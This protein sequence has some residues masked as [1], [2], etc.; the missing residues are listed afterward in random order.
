[1]V[2]HPTALK[3]EQPL[4]RFG[5]VADDVADTMHNGSIIIHGNARDVIG[6]AIQGGHIFVRGA[7]GNRAA[8]QMREYQ[9]NRPCLIIGETAEDYLA[10]YMAGGV[11]V[12]L[13]LSNS[14]DPVGAY[15]GTGMVGGKIYIRGK[16]ADTQ[17]GMP[18]K[19]ED[20]LN[21]LKASMIDG[22][23]PKTIFDE[24]SSMKYP[25][26]SKL[27]SLLPLDLFSRMHFLFFSGKYSKRLVV[28]QR[29]LQPLDLSLLGERLKAFFEVFELPDTFLESTLQS[30]FTI[31]SA[32]EEK[33]ETPVPPQEVP[34]EG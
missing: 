2:S 15:V 33:H 7:V 25:S 32:T 24:I 27:E 12:V 19:K 11:V 3:A 26:A 20:I 6:Q 8:I 28:E 18:P 34:V 1:M 5:N 29:R 16:V 10:E 23:I 30:E 17:I 22:Q 13:N 21:Y 9:T 14:P 31:I 4:R